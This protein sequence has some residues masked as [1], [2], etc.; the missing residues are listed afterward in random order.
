MYQFSKS[1]NFNDFE[2]GLCIDIALLEVY[3]RLGNDKE[4]FIRDLTID[5]EYDTITSTATIKEAAAKMKELGIP[6]LVVVNEDNEVLGVIADFDIVTG[7][8]AEGIST[9]TAKVTEYM[10]T[11][12]PVTKDT[13]V[14]VA[15]NRMRDLDVSVV[16]VIEKNKLIGVATITDCWGFLPE[17][18][19]DQIGLIPVSNP[20]LWNYAFTLFMVIIYSIFGFLAPLIGISGFLTAPL[21]SFGGYQA[22]YYL[23]DAHG[24]GFWFRYIE[25]PEKYQLFGWTLTIYGVL[26]LIIGVF[27]AFAIYHWAYA[28]YHLIKLDR[29]WK[30]IGFVIGLINLVIEWTLFFYAM[31]SGTI[32]GA[33][34]DFLGLILTILAIVALFLAVSR[35]WFFKE[36]IQ[37]AKEG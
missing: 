6:D 21:I 36:S 10:Y 18:Y 24:G 33:N 1:N 5:D 16:P 12:E 11:I 31:M 29:D 17:K 15:F 27:S 28:D 35:D 30:T 37:K 14:T 25:F 22:T 2:Y 9:D 7:A 32:P 19:E 26:F 13:P 23:F 4:Y 34:I 20:R 8:V 3:F